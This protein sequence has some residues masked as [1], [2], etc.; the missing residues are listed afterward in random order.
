[1]LVEEIDPE[2]DEVLQA[3]LRP[4]GPTT[5][6]KRVFHCTRALIQVEARIE[7]APS[8]GPSP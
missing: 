4:P 5:H 2:T 6:V 1:V 3:S 7:K 8:P